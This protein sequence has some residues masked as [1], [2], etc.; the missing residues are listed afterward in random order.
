[1]AAID[2]PSSPSLNQEFTAGTTIYVWDGTVWKVKSSTQPPSSSIVSYSANAPVGPVTGQ[3][4]VESDVD[5][6]II[7]TTTFYTKTETDNALALKA[8]L[9]SPTFTGTPAAPTAAVGTNTTQI[10]TTAFVRTEVAGIVDSAPSTLDTLN[11]LAAA[12]GDDP[13]FAT[14]VTNSIAEKVS[15]NGGDTIT[16]STGST[17]PLTIQNNGSGNSFVVN[18]EASDATAF[19]IGASGNVGIGGNTTGAKLE[20]FQGRSTMISNAEKYG[21]LFKYNTESTNGVYLGNLESGGLAVSNQGGEELF[22]IEGSKKVVVKGSATNSGPA[23]LELQSQGDATSFYNKEVFSV[24]VNTDP[25]EITRLTLSGANGFRAYFKI[26]VTGHTGTQGNGT[27]IKEFYWNAGTSAPVQISTYTQSDV[28]QSLPVIS[29]NNSINN[30][31]I[32]RL[33]SGHTGGFQ[34]TMMIEWIMPRDFSGN[35]GTIS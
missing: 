24:S 18:D 34:G 32:V 8:N 1:M 4:W 17:V 21:L 12:L 19:V 26:I 23:R 28:A 30:V 25:Q 22:L 6:N 15:K 33:N 14:T 31:C 16:V 35:T 11:E 7:D 27:N 29:F 10:A 20:V 2:F 9:A 3:V 5:V 13:N